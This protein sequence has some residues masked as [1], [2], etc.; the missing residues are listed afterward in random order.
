MCCKR[1]HIIFS[2]F[3]LCKICVQKEV[4]Y[5][6]QNH[7]LVMWPATNLLIF[8]MVRVWNW[9]KSLLFCLRY[10]PLVV[11]W[12]QNHITFVFI[13]R[14][15]MTTWCKWP[16]MKVWWRWG[17]F[18]TRGKRKVKDPHTNTLV[19]MAE[20]VLTLNTFECK[21]EYCKLRGC[22]GNG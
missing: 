6:F 22:R 2:T 8:K 13:K 4:I 7:I 18:K 5:N 12:S 14:C 11:F 10:D 20:M 15:H 21:G 1:Y 19:N 16:M 3:S 9:S 17:I